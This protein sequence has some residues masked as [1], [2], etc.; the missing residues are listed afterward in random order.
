MTEK[1]QTIAAVVRTVGAQ[2]Y[3][4][5]R[6]Y[7]SDNHPKISAAASIPDMKM[8]FDT[9]TVQK[10]VMVIVSEVFQGFQLTY[11]CLVAYQIP[12][13]SLETNLS[14]MKI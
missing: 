13:E 9:V 7:L 1:A 6:P 11:D 2:K 14:D 4:L 12:L 8:I 10:E 5:R 3:T